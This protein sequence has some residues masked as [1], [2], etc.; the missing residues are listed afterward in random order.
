MAM[1]RKSRAGK[2]AINFKIFLIFLLLSFNFQHVIAQD[3]I[4]PEHYGSKDS[5]PEYDLNV[6][7][8]KPDSVSKFTVCLYPLMP[9][10]YN[11]IA[12]MAYHTGSAELELNYDIKKDISL[13]GS[14]AI[15]YINYMDDPHFGPAVLKP[16][17]DYNAGM[18]WYFSRI[19]RSADIHVGLV[20]PKETAP[21]MVVDLSFDGKKLF[22]TG[23]RFGISHMNATIND[24]EVDFNYI[25]PGPGPDPDLHYTYYT[26]MTMGSITAGLVFDKLMDYK[27]ELDNKHTRQVT[28]KTRF[29]ADLILAPYT[30]YD[31]INMNGS[32]I[33]VNTNSTK[34]FFGFRIGFTYYSL[35]TFGG[36]WGVEL[37]YLPNAGIY[38]T[39]KIGIAFN[40]GIRL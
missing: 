21:G 26:N 13:Y 24:K 6:L 35:K 22:K 34:S 25:L 9:I 30:Q 17:H 38:F 32:V 1:I 15:S 3:K 33:D 8:N 20:H 27:I 2:N 4:N 7:R 18:I 31:N 19:I 14:A 37:G 11:E 40:P 5:V 12:P 10:E 16:W 28:K 36:S 23:L 29:Y 39:Y